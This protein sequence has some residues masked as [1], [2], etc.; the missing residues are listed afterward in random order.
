MIHYLFRMQNME[1]KCQ[2]FQKYERAHFKMPSV[3]HSLNDGQTHTLNH[4]IRVP[5]LS[6]V[7]LHELS[8]EPIRFPAHLY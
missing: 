8:S 6:S 3:P 1:M 5:V 4:D 7:C 2:K